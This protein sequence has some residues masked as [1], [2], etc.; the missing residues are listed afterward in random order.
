MAND[1][2]Y[3]I[4]VVVDPTG[5]ESGSSKSADALR[6]LEEQANR[7][8]EM[9]QKFAEIYIFHKLAHAIDLVTDAYTELQNRIRS[10]T[11]SQTEMNGIMDRTFAISQRTRLS[12]DDIVAQYQR[13]RLA[14]RDL[15]MSQNDALQFTENLA[16]AVQSSGVSAHAATLGLGDLTRGL[17][18]GNLNSRELREVM[19][20]LPILADTIAKH[21]HVTTA[22]L[23]EMAKK[24]ELNA[25]SLVAAFNEAHDELEARFAKMAPTIEQGWAILRN[26]AEKFFGELVTG[27]G[28]SRTFAEVLLFLGRNFE[29]VG[30]IVIIVAEAVGV[31]FAQRAIVAAING[32]KALTAAAMANPFSALL[33]VIAA[34][35]GALYEFRGATLSVNGETVKLADV[36]HVAWADIKALVSSVLDVIKELADTIS[37]GLGLQELGDRADS[38]FGEMF[39]GAAKLLDGMVNSFH[40]GLDAIWDIFKGLGKLVVGLFADLGNEIISDFEFLINK[41]IDGINA[42]DDF[43]RG[44]EAGR[45]RTQNML[46]DAGKDMAQVALSGFL[47][48]G[49][50]F[51][52]D[53]PATQAKIME[54]GVRDHALEVQAATGRVSEGSNKLIPRVEFDRIDYS[55][56]EA[57]MGS[58]KELDDDRKKDMSG[59][60]FQQKAAGFLDDV[61]AAAKVRQIQ[62]LID[63]YVAMGLSAQQAYEM[64]H[65]GAN[66]G[67]I[68]VQNK[69]LAKL[70]AQWK[71]IEGSVNPAA[72]AQMELNKAMDVGSKIAGHFGITT[73][74]VNHVLE[75]L[76]QKYADV[77]DP[78]GTVEK[79]LRDE[80]QLLT[81]EQSV[82]KE[83][84][85]VYKILN[86]LRQ[87][88]ILYTDKDAEAIQRLVARKELLG[89]VNAAEKT[90][91]KDLT[92]NTE[93]YEMSVRALDSMYA[94]GT[95][96][97]AQY[98]I[99]MKDLDTAFSHTNGKIF[100]TA[101]ETKGF[102]TAMIA[103]AKDV[104]DVG[105]LIENV[106]VHAFK[107]AEDAIVKFVT[108][109]KF[110]IKD[111]LSTVRDLINSILQDLTR[112]ILNKMLMALIGGGAGASSGLIGN[113]LMTPGFATG[114]SWTVPGSG[115]PDS[116][117]QMFRASPGETIHVRTPDQ[118]RAANRARQVAPGRTNVNNVVVFDAK[119]LAGVPRTPNGRQELMN[120]ISAD[121]AAFRRA[122][123]L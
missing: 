2:T 38:T 7:T 62:E 41:L 29:T 49:P 11:G 93:D 104:R 1:Y 28:I 94:K 31:Y 35:I 85:E 61:T 70:L 122:L 103:I 114:G 64:A 110:T 53:D 12:W 102:H 6:K 47:G 119:Q 5:A 3:T 117:L 69:A 44:T 68:E 108:S 34:V 23:L 87:K 16:V 73:E 63:K 46:K 33:I 107:S 45:A 10:V 60:F 42:V 78:I 75:R 32:I 15:G 43:W 80:I 106:W 8:H 9:L 71:Q 54:R 89:K 13:V 84:V 48:N 72:H 86:D 55:A 25:R 18:R 100:Q 76:K 121:P 59:N 30:K 82:H 98:R 118:E 91:W 50:T 14:T 120:A 27:S 111:L 65:K 17:Q 92:G 36:L 37:D 83:S 116:T 123:G 39:M 113:G 96:T 77:L 95:I 81:V 99:E 57:A 19:G 79:K 4:K 24:G 101:T 88:N 21:F 20:Q 90:I 74:D 40:L 112:L 115:P 22:E 58:L 109:F 105:G 67:D 52:P 97:A 66:L 26:G 56:K 51:D